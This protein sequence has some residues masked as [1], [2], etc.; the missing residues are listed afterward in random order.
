MSHMGGRSEPITYWIVVGDE[1]VTTGVGQ[2]V[3]QM[4]FGLRNIIADGLIVRVSSIDAD[5]EHGH[6]IQTEF[7]GAL[8]PALDVKFAPRVLGKCGAAGSDGSGAC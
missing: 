4:K 3:A 2:K 8:G 6:K 5:M 1:V 7:L